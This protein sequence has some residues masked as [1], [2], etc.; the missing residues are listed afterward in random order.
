MRKRLTPVLVE[1]WDGSR[2]PQPRIVG[3][4]TSDVVARPECVASPCPPEWV[5]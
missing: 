4:F 1:E 3:M 2:L 5:A